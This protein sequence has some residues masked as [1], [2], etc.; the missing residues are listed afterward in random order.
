MPCCKCDGEFE[1]FCM[2]DPFVEDD[3]GGAQSY[4]DSVRIVSH[5]DVGVTVALKPPLNRV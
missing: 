3:Y 1:F 2:E 5:G 4:P